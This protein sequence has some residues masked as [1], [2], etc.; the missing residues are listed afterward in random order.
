MISAFTIVFTSPLC[1]SKSQ[2]RFWFRSLN[3]HESMN[4]LLIQWYLLFIST[5]VSIINAQ[6]LVRSSHKFVDGCLTLYKYGSGQSV[7]QETYS[8]FQCLNYK[9]LSLDVRERGRAK[10]AGRLGEK[11][12]STRGQLEK[13]KVEIFRLIIGVRYRKTIIFGLSL[14]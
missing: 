9:F 4:T 10:C 12:R 14:S 13:E 7:S 8:K 11:E 2:N 3:F 5:I 1:T 6:K